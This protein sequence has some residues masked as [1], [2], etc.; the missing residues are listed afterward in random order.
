MADMILVVYVL[1]SFV[2]IIDVSEIFFETRFKFSRCNVNKLKRL[3]LISQVLH[4]MW[5]VPFPVSVPN[6]AFL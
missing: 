1:N 2:R 6:L 4:Q 3:D 5:R